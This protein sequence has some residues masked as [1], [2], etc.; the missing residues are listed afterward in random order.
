MDSAGRR[1][2]LPARVER[3]LVAG[4]PANVAVF[5]VAPDKMLGWLRAPRAEDLPFLPRRYASLPVT[6]RLTGRGGVEPEAAR[7]LR[8]DL[9]VDVG[10]IAP[11]F[12]ATADRTQAAIGVPYVL[13]D[14][15][16]ART[17]DL[18]R[19]LGHLLDRQARADALAAYAERTLSD[20]RAVFALRPSDAKPPRVLYAR[21]PAG[22]S[23]AA[24]GTFLME[25]FEAA[26]AYNVAELFGE[27]GF[28]VATPAQ[29]K[30][31]APDHLFVTDAQFARE[32]ASAEGFRDT[33]AAKAG[34]IHLVPD[35]PFGWIEAP[36]SVNRLIGL[37]WLIEVLHGP[38]PGPSLRERA[39]EFHALFYGVTPPDAVIERLPAGTM[40][41][42]R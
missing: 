3:V 35:V 32:L 29:V 31:W 25:I 41:R 4:P 20:A 37:A 5:A 28:A 17:P 6:G 2:S 10:S 40:R 16:L 9:I 38:M 15:R 39:R 11:G 18:L 26:G 23:T 7:A 21:G 36:P 19:T 12:V 24:R 27:T 13:L 42:E 33:P 34:R 22:L 8:P 14:G 30:T 1:V